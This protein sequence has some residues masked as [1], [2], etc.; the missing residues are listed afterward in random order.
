MDSNEP[1]W[2]EVYRVSSLAEAEVVQSLLQSAGV[3]SRLRYDATSRVILGPGSVNPWSMVRVC[4]RPDKR[5]RAL[6]IIEQALDVKGD[7][8]GEQ[9]E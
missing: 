7:E 2:V 9:Q 6:E 5:E 3:N 4:V 8:E 1:E